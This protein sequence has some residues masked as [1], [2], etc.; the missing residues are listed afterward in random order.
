M[1]LKHAG[2]GQARA[3]ATGASAANAV[4][5]TAPQEPKEHG[6]K[7]MSDMFLLIS[8][9]E[10]GQSLLL[11]KLI[12]LV[13]HTYFGGH[14]WAFCEEAAATESGVTTAEA[15]VCYVVFYLMCLSAFTCSLTQSN[16]G[17]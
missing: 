14:F 7:Q 6:F 16:C 12:M 3:T 17:K 13:R 8:L 5:E 15:T 2:I 4:G 1:T 9:C 10:M 11:V